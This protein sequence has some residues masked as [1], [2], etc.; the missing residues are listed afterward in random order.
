MP[1]PQV[2][3]QVSDMSARLFQM[4]VHPFRKCL[5]LYGVSF[6]FELG[7]ALLVAVLR[8]LLT[9]MLGD[10]VGRVEAQPFLVVSLSRHLQLFLSFD[11]RPTVLLPLTLLRIIESVRRAANSAS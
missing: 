5:L 1:V 9:V 10:G 7:E 6:V 4:F 8:P 2:L 3:E 11:Q